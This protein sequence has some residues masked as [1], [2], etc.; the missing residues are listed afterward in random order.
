MLIEFIL[1]TISIFPFLHFIPF[2]SFSLCLVGYYMYIET[3]SPRVNGDTATL[4]SP[5]YRSFN[6]TCLSFKAHMYGSGIGTLKIEKIE[7][8][9]KT[10]LFTKAGNQQNKWHSFSVNLQSGG[11]YKVINSVES[12]FF[13][14]FSGYGKRF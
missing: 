12:R 6:T 11:P 1:Q 3:S 2:L 10:V 14:S 4:I 5:D 9:S 13:F 7:G 8:N